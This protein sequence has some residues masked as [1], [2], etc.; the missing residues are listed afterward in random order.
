MKHL[1]SILIFLSFISLSYAED[2]P[3]PPLEDFVM[4]GNSQSYILQRCVALYKFHAQ[5]QAMLKEFQGEEYDNT[6]EAQY[7]RNSI[8]LSIYQK[9]FF[10]NGELSE[11]EQSEMVDAY[12]R[13]KPKF[14]WEDN[15]ICR[16]VLASANERAES[17]Q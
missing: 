6:D 10:P 2:R 9:V 11:E 5:T 7:Y 16:E 15:A 8:R 1:L 14:I 12:M 13:T 3:L 17:N 4:Q